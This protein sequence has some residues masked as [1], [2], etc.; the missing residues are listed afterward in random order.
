MNKFETRQLIVDNWF[1]KEKPLGPGKKGTFEKQTQ[2]TKELKEIVKNV[3]FYL[4]DIS[5]LEEGAILSFDKRV[6]WYGGCDGDFKVYVSIDNGNWQEI[7]YQDCENTGWN[8]LSLD[9]SEY[10]GETMRLQFRDY[11]YRY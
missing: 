8:T 7:Y 5:M 4:F 3:D 10:Q 2:M 11:F 1:R 6:D 9:I